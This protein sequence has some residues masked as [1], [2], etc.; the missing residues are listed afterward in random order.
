M[1]KIDFKV[2]KISFSATKGA[3]VNKNFRESSTANA[4]ISRRPLKN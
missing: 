2:R 1:E 4:T 3:A